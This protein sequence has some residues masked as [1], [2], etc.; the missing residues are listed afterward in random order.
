M[1]QKA[2]KEATRRYLADFA[3]DGHSIILWRELL[4]YGFDPVWLRD[5]VEIILSGEGKYA[6]Y[7]S[8]GKGQAI[9]RH[10]QSGFAVYNHRGA[11]AGR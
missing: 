9:R 8:R 5:Q 6:I 7:V 3:D 11:R 4:N 10:P 1:N 2:L